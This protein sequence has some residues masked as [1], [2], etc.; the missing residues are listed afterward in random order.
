MDLTVCEQ[1]DTHST[2]ETSDSLKI[3]LGI[4]QGS[5]FQFV[6]SKTCKSRR[7]KYAPVLL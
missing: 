3:G 5:V 6:K 2:N 7:Q 1:Q 4:I